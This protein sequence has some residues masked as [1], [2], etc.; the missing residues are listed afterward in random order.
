MALPFSKKMKRALP[1]GS[2]TLTVAPPPGS[3]AT[4]KAH[5]RSG[6]PLASAHGISP[7]ASNCPCPARAGEDGPAA[8]APPDAGAAAPPPGAAKLR[9]SQVPELLSLAV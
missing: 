9:I 3:R 5:W 2:E 6:A 4:S 7:R 8:F 1:L